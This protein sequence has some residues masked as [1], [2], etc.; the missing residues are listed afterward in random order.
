MKST[1]IVI[2]V[3]ASHLHVTGG[4]AETPLGLSQGTLLHTQNTD[5]PCFQF[6]YCLCNQ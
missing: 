4:E 6:Y 1:T 3:N 2:S 5:G